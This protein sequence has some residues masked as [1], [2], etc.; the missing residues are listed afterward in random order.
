[1]SNYSWSGTWSSNTY[2]EV[3]TFVKHDNIAYV[4]TNGFQGST[5]PPPLDMLNW[6]VFVIGYQ[7]PVTPTPTG[8]M[9][10][11]P[12]TTETPTPTPSVTT[13]VT[14]TPS[15]TPVGSPTNTPSETETPTPTPTVTET[16]TGTPNETTT[17]TPTVTGTPSETNTPTPTPTV[18][19][20]PTNT[21]TPTNTETPTNTP[22]PE[23]TTTPTNT[24]TPEPT[25]TPTNTLTPTVT[26]TG[27]PIVIPTSG[28][29]LYVDAGRTSSYSG[30]G[31]QWNDLSVNNNTGTLQNSPTYSTSN[32][33]I[34]T[35]NGSNQYTTFSSPSNIPIGNSNYT[36]SVWF[37][38]SSLGQIGFVGWGN[39]GTTNQV[40]AL[41]LS[42]TG[43]AHYW[44]GNDLAVNTSLSINTWYNVVAR[45][46]GTNRQLWLNNVLIG[47]DTPGSGHN[48]PNAN[49]LTIGTTNVNEYFNGKISN[50]EIYDRAISDSEIAEIYNNFIYRF[51]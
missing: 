32:G 13:T 28:L 37:N 15:H 49:N 41:R 2:Y 12:T 16:P 21:P 20:T 50:V 25:T 46:D 39:Y 9:L 3:N 45:F 34:L 24:L 4:S 26:P 6:N 51:T 31:N 47:G 33:G 1:M 29:S 7:V 43:F 19:E 5:T 42:A 11:T 14:N 30:S 35:F 18:T 23:P 27:T 38:A 22:T 44:W 36:I 10:V 17:P 48:V 8:T 40:T